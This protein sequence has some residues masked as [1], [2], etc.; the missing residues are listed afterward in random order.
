MRHAND[1]Y[2]H[3]A[4]LDA[5]AA[6]VCLRVQSGRAQVAFRCQLM[7]QSGHWHLFSVTCSIT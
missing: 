3:L 7:T 2:W 4:D 5:Q 1:R 6:D